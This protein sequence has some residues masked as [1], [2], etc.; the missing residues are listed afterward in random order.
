MPKI[1]VIMP[2]GKRPVEVSGK[3]INI[4]FDYVYNNIIN[5]AGTDA[6]W[7][8]FRIDEITKSGIISDQYLKEILESDLVL[9]D[10]SSPNSNVFYEL[11][12][13]QS[14]STGGTILIAI[15]GSSIPYDLSSQRVFSYDFNEGYVFNW[16]EIFGKDYGRFKEF[17]AKKYGIDWI[18]PTFRTCKFKNL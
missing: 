9:A 8:V 16:E 10:V 4:D 3:V 2:F 15:R 6:G 13:R 14:I 18:N 7:T 17:L 11:G 5:P 1:F 12:I